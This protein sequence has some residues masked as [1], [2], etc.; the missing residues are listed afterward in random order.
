VVAQPVT[1]LAPDAAIDCSRKPLLARFRFA[2]S[3]D[4]IVIRDAVVSIEQHSVFH[5]TLLNMRLRLTERRTAGE[6]DGHYNG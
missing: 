4:L 6:D 1:L 2:L 5:V 3:D